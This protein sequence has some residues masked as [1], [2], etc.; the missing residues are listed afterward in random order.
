[1][2]NSCNPLG[3]IPWATAIAHALAPPGTRKLCT[4]MRRR[5]TAIQ[6]APSINEAISS[7]PHSLSVGTDV[8]AAAGTAGRWPS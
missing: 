1:M 7:R 2:V 3:S 8:A 5:P 6:P 4:H